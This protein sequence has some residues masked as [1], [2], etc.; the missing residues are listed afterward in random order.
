MKIKTPT[1]FLTF[2]DG[3]VKICTVKN[4]RIQDCVK[5][6]CYGNRTLSMSRYY[7]ARAASTSIDK[8]IHV[9]LWPVTTKQDAVID[10]VRYKI[11]QAQPLKDTNPP[12]T[13]L[14]LRE[15]GVISDG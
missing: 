6:L 8:V 11:E 9:P 15:I 3:H 13:V 2:N 14:S 5:T 1:E 12:A 7:T 4:N 10:N